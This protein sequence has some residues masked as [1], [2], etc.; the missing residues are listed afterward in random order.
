MINDYVK[1]YTIGDNVLVYMPYQS[2][3]VSMR[4]NQTH[5]H[6][7]TLDFTNNDML[8][9]YCA[10]WCIARGFLINVE[11]RNDDITYEALRYWV[12]NPHEDMSVDFIQFCELVDIELLNVIMEGF[13]RT[14]KTYPKPATELADP[15]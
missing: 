7:D 14:R 3:S 11:M 9:T 12:L 1:R 10:V 13:N 5:E 8:E 4:L 2:Y 15:N 6:F